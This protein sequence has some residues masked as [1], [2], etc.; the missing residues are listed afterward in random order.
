MPERRSNLMQPPPLARS[1]LIDEPLGL[2]PGPPSNPRD[3]HA[4][5]R[6]LPLVPFHLGIGLTR[7]FELP[8]SLF[9]LTL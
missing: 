7:R 1:R 6:P 2:A 9:P 3:P 8:L 4:R 5:S